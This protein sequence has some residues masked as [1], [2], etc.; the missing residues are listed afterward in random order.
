MV[1]DLLYDA[2]QFVQE[3]HKK[4][5]PMLGTGDRVSSI[6]LWPSGQ[7]PPPPPQSYAGELNLGFLTLVQ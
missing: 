2:L 4:Y 1:L 6:H 3:Q 7:P 5:S